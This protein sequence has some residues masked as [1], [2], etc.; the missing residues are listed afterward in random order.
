MR[1]GEIW[2]ARSSA[3]PLM[4][5][6]PTLC[7]KSCAPMIRRGPLWAAFLTSLSLGRPPVKLTDSAVR[8]MPTHVVVASAVRVSER[9]RRSRVEYVMTTARLKRAEATLRQARRQ[10]LGRVGAAPAALQ[11]AA[12]AAIGE[13]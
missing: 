13:S 3:Q 6:N 11:T 7:Q 10:I 5:Q 1:T 2:R 12:C 8:P 4:H 9:R